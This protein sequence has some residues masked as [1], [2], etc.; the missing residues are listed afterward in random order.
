V[1][2]A[3]N[4]IIRWKYGVS[5]EPRADVF[6]N[7]LDCLPRTT[8]M[9]ASLDSAAPSKMGGFAAQIRNQKA[10]SRVPGTRPPLEQAD[11]VE[12]K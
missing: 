5:E 8:P 11:L 4:P 12:I 9:V 3:H 6:C 1:I 2:P 10:F 7:N